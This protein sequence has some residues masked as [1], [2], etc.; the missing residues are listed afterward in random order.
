[1]TKEVVHGVTSLDAGQATAGQIAVLIRGHWGIENRGH[2]VRDVV[3][4]QDD[5]H[6]YAGTGA[7]VMATL[8][9]LVLGLLRLAGMTRI[10]RTLE[11][12]AGERARIFPIMASAISPT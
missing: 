11:Y 12:I 7:Q 10:N 4:R 3:Y 1:L 6:A 2:W 9:N 5:Q 8:R